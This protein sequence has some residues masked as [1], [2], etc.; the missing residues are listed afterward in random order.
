MIALSSRRAYSSRAA[1]A[2]ERNPRL[3]PERRITACQC[4]APMPDKV[5][6]FDDT[7]AAFPPSAFLPSGA[8]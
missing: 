6:P 7:I 3:A 8:T 5:S 1:A 2:R 4:G